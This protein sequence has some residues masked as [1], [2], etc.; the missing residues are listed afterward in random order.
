MRNAPFP[1]G[2]GVFFFLLVPIPA[3]QKGG[4]PI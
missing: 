4:E 3:I 2:K 1:V